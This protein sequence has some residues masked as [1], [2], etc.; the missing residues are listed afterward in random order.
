[1]KKLTVKIALGMAVAALITTG[2]TAGAAGNMSAAVQ[3][4]QTEMMQQAAPSMASSVVMNGMMPG[5]AMDMA[6]Q[7]ASTDS[8]GSQQ[9]DLLQIVEESIQT[10]PAQ[11]RNQLAKQMTDGRKLLLPE[12]AVPSLTDQEREELARSMVSRNLPLLKEINGQK[13]S[14]VIDPDPAIN[15]IMKKIQERIFKD[16]YANIAQNGQNTY[17]ALMQ[18]QVVQRMINNIRPWEFPTR[19]KGKMIPVLLPTISEQVSAQMQD[20]AK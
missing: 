5:P 19:F 11:Q 15:T 16:S 12:Q 8:S 17:R 1:M 20:G 3:Q 13:D 4:M 7:Q 14:G 9:M 10:L 18:P 6:S 2:G